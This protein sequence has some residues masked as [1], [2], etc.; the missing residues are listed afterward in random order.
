MLSQKI[1]SQRFEYDSYEF[2]FGEGF[3]LNPVDSAPTDRTQVNSDGVAHIK[4]RKEGSWWVQ[5]SDSPISGLDGDSGIRTLEL[6]NKKYSDDSVQVT[7]KMCMTRMKQEGLTKKV[8]E[9][10]LNEL[11]KEE[12]VFRVVDEMVSCEWKAQAEYIM[13]LVGPKKEACTGIKNLY[14]KVLYPK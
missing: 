10:P 13:S 11:S 3:Y 12:F 9:T 14:G 5:A 7:T 2:D 8:L 4:F 6:L 1:V